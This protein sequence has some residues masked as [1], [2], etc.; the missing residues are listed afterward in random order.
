MVANTPLMVPL[1]TLRRLN[2]R[3]N[4]S[5]KILTCLSNSSNMLISLF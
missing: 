1:I 3:A 2:L 4:D 5:D